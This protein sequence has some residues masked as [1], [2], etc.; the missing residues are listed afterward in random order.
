MP[1]S[2][3]IMP[4]EI[5]KWYITGLIIIFIKKE[6][7]EQTNISLEWIRYKIVFSW[8]VKRSPSSNKTNL[9]PTMDQS[10]PVLLSAKSLSWV[11]RALIWS[12]SSRRICETRSRH[13]EGVRKGRPKKGPDRH[14]PLPSSPA[15]WLWHYWLDDEKLVGFGIRGLVNPLLPTPPMQH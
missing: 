4:Y 14:N 12:P 3:H 1:I 2:F 13:R 6:I 8:S 10:H 7:D 9:H 15:E 11:T 5:M